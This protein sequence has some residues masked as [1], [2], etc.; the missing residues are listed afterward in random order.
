VNGRVRVLPPDA[1][2]LPP[3]VPY[4]GDSESG[5]YA[6][7]EACLTAV[8][9]ADEP[10]L[11]VFLDDAAA[12]VYCTRPTGHPRHEVHTCRLR[13]SVTGEPQAV[14]VWGGE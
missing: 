4:V 12:G 7:S 8:W 5:R 13:D 11:M 9:A 2:G 3:A 6:D 1:P 14:I 10:D